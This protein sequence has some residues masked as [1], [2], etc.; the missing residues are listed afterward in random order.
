[1]LSSHT[2]RYFTIL[3][4]PILYSNLP[5]L[6]P[7]LSYPY[8]LLYIPHISS[9]YALLSYPQYFIISLVILYIIIPYLTLYFIILY[10]YK[11]SYRSYI[12]ILSDAGIPSTSAAT[13]AYFSF[14]AAIF[15]SFS[16][17]N[18]SNLFS[19]SIVT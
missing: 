15:S 16:C 4:I 8:I 18:L 13:S 6:P 1:M 14:I 5:I 12:F 9:L 2:P 17:L 7:I 11:I 3:Y 19:L 10:P